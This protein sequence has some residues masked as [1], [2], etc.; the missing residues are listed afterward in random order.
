[1]HISSDTQ[2]KGTSISSRRPLSKYDIWRSWD[3]CLWF[4][5]TLEEEYEH[6]AR[7]KKRR[8]AQGKGVKGF[9]G[10]YKKDHASS[11]ESLPAGPVPD[12]VAQDIH[13]HLPTLTKRGTVFRASQETID[14]R[15]AELIAFVRALFSD[16]MPALIQ[17]I[18]VSRIVSEFFG[19]WGSDFEFA[20]ESR[21][22]TTIPRKSSTNSLFSPYFS[23][24]QPSLPSSDTTHSPSKAYNKSHRPTAPHSISLTNVTEIVEEPRHPS[25][26]SRKSPSRPLSTSSDSSAFSESGSDTSSLSGPAIDENV[27]I[28]TEHSLGD[29]FNPILEALPEEQETTPESPELYREIKPKPRASAKE[30]EAKRSFSIFG[31]SLPHP[32][33]EQKFRAS[34]A[35]ISTFMTTGSA[36]AVIPPQDALPR[37]IPSISE[38]LEG[39]ATQEV[40]D[41][42]LPASVSS[43]RAAINCPPSPTCTT[44]PSSIFSTT[45]TLLPTDSITIKAIHD[46]SI[47]LLR[48]A[49]G[50][51]FAEVKQRLCNKF[52]GQEGIPLSQ[53][54]NVVF[55]P[56]PAANRTDVQMIISES[57]WEELMSTVQGNKITLRIQDDSTT[58]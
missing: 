42:R 48:V 39:F 33:K 41:L 5:Q 26:S 15:Q 54:Y 2:S 17:E 28:V 31:L 35:S 52:I 4:Q 40:D 45:S 30:R 49:R 44:K 21:S 43:T 1:M 6:A 13:Q 24:S 37:P 34:L 27:S 23:A 46:T 10:L 8:L 57:D 7:E 32:I 58:I 38:S 19:P 25:R 55:V 14:R 20:Q 29:Q 51:E 53:T 12:S 18:R 16:E 22:S 47:I 36:N 11:W 3:D 50:M 9:N 56:P